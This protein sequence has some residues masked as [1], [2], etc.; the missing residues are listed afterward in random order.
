MSNKDPI[1]SS[2]SQ[3]SQ[4]DVELFVADC[5]RRIGL[6]PQNDYSKLDHYGPPLEPYLH[7]DSTAVHDNEDNNPYVFNHRDEFLEE[8]LSFADQGTS[9]LGEGLGQLEPNIGKAVSSKLQ[10]VIML[11]SYDIDVDLG[12][13]I[14]PKDLALR[15]LAI[16]SIAVSSSLGFVDYVTATGFGAHSFMEQAK[17]TNRSSGTTGEFEVCYDSIDYY[18]DQDI[19]SVKESDYEEYPDFYHYPGKLKIS[20]S[21]HRIE[22]S[23]QHELPEAEERYAQTIHTERGDITTN[24]ISIRIDKDPSA[25]HGYSVDIGRDPRETSKLSRRGDLL[26]T[27]L[28]ATR[29]DGSHFYTEADEINESSFRTMTHNL[30]L[31]LNSIDERIKLDTNLKGDS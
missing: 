24:T 31:L 23:L 10:E 20:V 17:I 11:L 1:N 29:D 3:Y 15:D 30:S 8:L 22:F 12:T 16:L 25:P 7:E 27:L 9:I 19:S 6:G 4:E 5:M 21:D 2:E 26:G 13:N 18:D 14:G 28:S